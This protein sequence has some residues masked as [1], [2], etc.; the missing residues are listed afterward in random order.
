MKRLSKQSIKRYDAHQLA[1]HIDRFMH[2]H[3]ID[4]YRVDL[5]TRHVFKKYWSSTLPDSLGPH[6]YRFHFAYS[7]NHGLMDLLDEVYSKIDKT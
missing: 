3:G 5:V 4:D 6:S 7:S 1:K 2:H